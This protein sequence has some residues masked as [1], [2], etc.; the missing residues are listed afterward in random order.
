MAHLRKDEDTNIIHI[1][2]DSDICLCG[3]MRGWTDQ[4]KPVKKRYGCTCYSCQNELK[5]LKTFKV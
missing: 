2:T 4:Q 3:L 1:E 5:D